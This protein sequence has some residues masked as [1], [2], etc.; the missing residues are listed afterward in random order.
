[1]MRKLMLAAGMVVAMGGGALA[2]EKTLGR[3]D[4]D[5]VFVWKDSDAQSEGYNLINSGVHKS[6]PVL[7][8]RLFSCMVPKGTR[9]VVTDAGFFSSTILITSGESTGCRGVIANE[10]LGQ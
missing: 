10:D 1:M 2:Q 3:A 4:M 5:T 9:A 7:I 8:M 6:N